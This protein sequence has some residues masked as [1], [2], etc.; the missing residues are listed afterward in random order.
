MIAS[1]RTYLSQWPP[2]LGHGTLVN[3]ML[4]L[5]LLP[6]Y[7]GEIGVARAK[8]LERSNEHFLFYLALF[9]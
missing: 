8:K 1:R 7:N 4:T 5:L 6:P 2:A 3:P 9:G